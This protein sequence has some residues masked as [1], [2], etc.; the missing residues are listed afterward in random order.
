M[1][2]S[3]HTEND[4]FKLFLKGEPYRSF[5]L[6]NQLHVF[7]NVGTPALRMDQ[8][9]VFERIKSEIDTFL[10][11]GYTGSPRDFLI[12]GGPGSGKSVLAMAL[13]KYYL[14]DNPHEVRFVTAGGAIK[15][16][17]LTGLPATIVPDRFVYLNQVPQNDTEIVIIDEM[18]RFKSTVLTDFQTTYS[19]LKVV[20][21]LFD[22][23]Q[24]YK[25]DLAQGNEFP[26]DP[27]DEYE[28]TSQYRCSGDLGYLKWL[29]KLFYHRYYPFSRDSIFFDFEIIENLGELQRLVSNPSFVIVTYSLCSGQLMTYDNDN[30]LVIEDV[31]HGT[32]V[33]I[34]SYNKLR[35]GTGG[36]LLDNRL[37]FDH[38]CNGENHYGDIN[39]IHGLEAENI[40][41]IIG[42]EL[43]SDGTAIHCSNWVYDSEIYRKNVLGFTRVGDLRSAA[44]GGRNLS[45]N[46]KEEMEN[47]IR[48]GYRILLTR[49]LQSCKVYCC[50]SSLRDYFLHN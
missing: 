15:D 20:I 34:S 25:A 42:D 41:V 33:I 1:I 17:I 12:K 14:Q 22:P 30:N 2:G 11:A 16:T 21:L 18:N 4:V 28:L 35:R 8:Y 7:F 49:G 6:Y 32:Q 9:G 45:T 44:E 48:N 27:G 3:I 50:D 23:L 13:L 47:Y 31:S 10:G 24:S 5:S 29:D 43:V 46:E 19:A 36:R 26:V 37:L 39:N 38:F 40:I